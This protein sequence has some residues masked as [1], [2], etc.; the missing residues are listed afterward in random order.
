MGFVV[1]PPADMPRMR[2]L[3]E[4]EASV[5]LTV[6]PASRVP[7]S[8][9]LT[10]PTVCSAQWVA[11]LLHP[12]ASQ[13]FA[14]FRVSPPSASPESDGGGRG[15]SPR[16]GSH[17]S[18]SSPRQQPYRITAAVAFVLLPFTAR[19]W[20][21]AEALS[22][23]TRV[24]P[25][26]SAKPTGLAPEGDREW[27]A[28]RAFDAVMLRSAEADPHVT[29]ALLTASD[30]SRRLESRRIASGHAMPKQRSS[31]RDRTT[32][33]VGHNPASCGVVWGRQATRRWSFDPPAA[34]ATGRCA[35]PRR[36]HR[37]GAA[38]RARRSPRSGQL[39]GL[40]PLT[41]PWCQI[42]VASKMT[43]DPSMG[44]VPLQ[45]LS[46]PVPAW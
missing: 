13:G 17:P 36:S 20:G 7:P 16:R 31:R 14:A 46:N 27:D 24:R 26:P 38:E 30:R 3:R 5:V 39:Q 2:S 12:A 42:A 28:G 45:G 18:K 21:W 19:L 32:G 34:E 8:W 37:G 1:C 33:G 25:K 4:A 40:A 11:G 29:D 43:L 6:P 22:T 10:T 23:L 44:F 9:F 15:P 35:A 41:S